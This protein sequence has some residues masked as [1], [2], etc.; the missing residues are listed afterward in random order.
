MFLDKYTD[1]L[2]EKETRRRRNRKKKG[3]IGIQEGQEERLKEG[4][5]EKIKEKRKE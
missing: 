4:D 5:E 1:G 3:K 2:E